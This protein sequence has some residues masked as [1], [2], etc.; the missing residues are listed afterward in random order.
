MSIL[1]NFAT[2]S[3]FLSRRMFDRIKERL[4]Q[5]FDGRD[6]LSLSDAKFA[7]IVAFGYKP[8]KAQLRVKL[9]EDIS[10]QKLYGLIQH[11]LAFCDR[12]KNQ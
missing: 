8:S 12:G 5:L 10:R 7:W 9:G 2:F 1:V 3:T 4:D 11:E 6:E